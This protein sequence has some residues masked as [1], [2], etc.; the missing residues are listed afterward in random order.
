MKAHRL[1]NHS[2]PCYKMV[3]VSLTPIQ[4]TPRKTVPGIQY[5]GA[6][7]NPA[8]QSGACLTPKKSKW[9]K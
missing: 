4:F 5:I 9:S 2:Q 6:Q 3:V 7:P 1:S 8:H